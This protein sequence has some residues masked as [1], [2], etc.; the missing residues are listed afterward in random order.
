MKY[1]PPSEF[2][3]IA[4]PD[5]S[6]FDTVM[7]MGISDLS[8][9]EN[10]LVSEIHAILDIEFPDDTFDKRTIKNQW[11]KYF[12]KQ[13]FHVNVPT[14]IKEILKLTKAI[15][16]DYDTQPDL[17]YI[18]KQIFDIEQLNCEDWRA[19][20]LLEWYYKKSK[21]KNKD[22]LFACALVLLYELL[23]RELFSKYNTSIAL[24]IFKKVLS[25][26]KIIP[27]S[28]PFIKE[29]NIDLLRKSDI[30]ILNNIILNAIE[31]QYK[32]SCDCGFWLT[33]EKQFFSED[34]LRKSLEKYSSTWKNSTL[35]T[36]VKE[37]LEGAQCY[38]EDTIL[39]FFEQVWVG[40][41]LAQEIYDLKLIT[42]F[43]SDYNQK[44]NSDRV[45]LFLFIDS[46]IQGLNSYSLVYEKIRNYNNL[47]KA[48]RANP[49]K[50]K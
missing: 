38:D 10:D 32:K 27:L 20:D 48:N 29:I 45:D 24:L 11:H 1:Q 50:N 21:S 2:E 17:P 3:K 37:L 26:A 31:S 7:F 22:V 46:I 6:Y 14:K 42:E 13:K 18:L 9:N 28:Y 49:K 8:K 23:H 5:F 33:Y 36:A 12:E 4:N 35:Y 15:L 41:H 43:I 16:Y 47:K 30:L 44:Q 19:V 25:D 40:K 39:Y 34:S